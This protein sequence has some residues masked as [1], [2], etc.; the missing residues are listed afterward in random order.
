MDAEPLDPQGE[1]QDYSRPSLLDEEG[2]FRTIKSWWQDD[3]KHTHNWRREAQED[4]DFVSGKQFSTE[5][6]QA[7]KDSKRVPVVFNRTL[8]MI[9]AVAGMEINGRHEISYLPRNTQDAAVNEVLTGASKWMADECDGEDEESEAF[10]H[11]LICGMGFTEH[12]LDFDEEP[13]GKYIENGVNPIEMYWDRTARKKNLSD[14]RR[15]HRVRK[16]PLSDALGLFPGY[17]ASELDAVWAVGLEPNEPQKTLE[18]R[19]VRDENVTAY[20]DRAEVTIVQTQ[21]WERETYWL[22]ADPATNTKATLSDDKYKVLKARAEQLG[23]KLMAVKL[24]KKV[25]K[26][27]F[28]G[29]KILESGDGP[30]PDRFSFTCIT[31]QLNHNKG[32]WFGLV[33]VMRDPAMWANKFLVQSM[34][35]LN[36]NAKGGILAETDAFEDQAEAEAT[37][38][39]PEA[40]T[41]VQ[42]GALTNK[43]IDKKP[44]AEMPTAFF[45]LMGMAVDA[46]KDVTG[47]NLEMLGLKDINQPGVLEAQRKQAGMTVLAT[48]FDSLRRMRKQ[49]GRIRL[50]FIQNF[51][52]DGRLIRIVGNDGAK[53][54]PLV[55]DHTTGEYDVVV[56]DTPS[57]PNQKQA[58][59]AIIQPMLVA[60]KDQLM[61]RPDI[62][63]MLL[64]YSPLPSRAVEAIKGALTQSTPDQDQQHQLATAAA[65]AKIAKDQSTADLNKSKAGATEAT[66]AYDFAMAHNLLRKESDKPTDGPLDIAKKVAEIDTEAAK[67]DHLRSQTNK[68]HADA[69]AARV[70]ALIDMLTPI[71][72]P[73]PS[74]Q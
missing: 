15:I 28:L 73:Q 26:Q 50:Y 71:Q 12:R 45:E 57:S 42:K 48:M 51:L 4:F 70:G 9:K 49:V 20:P 10:E 65:V 39:R 40:I 58:N 31:G 55:R 17:T 72:Q 47:I 74:L 60:F 24:K 61:T 62:F 29:S 25:Y 34:H 8:T 67:A 64:D 2:Q 27:A 41:W 19:R 63:A 11:A 30:L 53:V 36:S 3:A 14:A 66:A 13:E 68:A 44:S 59:W 46:L 32:V 33:R 22:I 6:E 23:I 21:W 16:M 56:D 69:H 38:A 1:T 52:S 43:K 35:I 37:Y 7:L 18:E 54:I 5:D